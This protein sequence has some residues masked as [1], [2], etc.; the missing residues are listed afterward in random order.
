MFFLLIYKIKIGMKL[1]NVRRLVAPVTYMV[2]DIDDM[3]DVDTSSGGLTTL[4]IPNI[5]Q[6]GYDQVPKKIYI[7]DVSN[8]A[9]VGKITVVCIGGNTI[10]NLPQIV[11]DSNGV[12]AEIEIADRTRYIA[13]LNTDDSPAPSGGGDIK[14]PTP[15]IKISKVDTGVGYPSL[16]AYYLPFSS[17]GNEEFLNHNPKYYLF[18][19][20]RRHTS[21]KGADKKFKPTGYYHPTHQNGINFPSGAFYS[22]ST[23]FPLDTEYALTSGAYNK[24]VLS[25]NAFQF[26]RVYDKINN[27]WILP[28][29]TDFG[30]N[31]K[32]F[33]FPA[34]HKQ[35]TTV[36]NFKIAIG[37][38]NPDTN[39]NKP[40]L[41]GELSETFRMNFNIKKQSS[42]PLVYGFYG[43]DLNIQTTGLRQKRN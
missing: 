3:I 11:L 40:I 20:K 8:N 21:R 10:N 38:T 14:I 30:N 19:A 39:S 29:L 22:G 6:N 27:A 23:E 16:S 9:S 26:A 25:F 35:Y 37:I 1:S 4:Y 34:K 18:I 17:T 33:K 31:I 7:N 42:F 41:F 13:N 36:V 43:L 28:T 32:Q 15:Q 2:L 12:S 24:T 5:V